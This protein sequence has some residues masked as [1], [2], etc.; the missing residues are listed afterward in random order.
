MHN[1]KM[2]TF[3][4]LTSIIIGGCA[5]IFTGTVQTIRFESTPKGAMVEMDGIDMG[6]TPITLPINQTTFNSRIMT[7]RKKG[8]ENRVFE[9]KRKFNVITLFNLFFPPAFIVDM[10]TGSMM[11]YE[12]KVNRVELRKR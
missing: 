3:F 10:V 7:M 12:Q 5:T 11:E 9:L 4:F 1:F 6:T 8:Y 2:A